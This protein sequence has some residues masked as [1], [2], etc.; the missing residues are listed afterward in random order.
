MNALGKKWRLKL[1]MVE[2]HICDTEGVFSSE[3]KLL[4]SPNLIFVLNALQTSYLDYSS[5]QVPYCA[6][7][8]LTEGN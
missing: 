1:S 6:R 3:K 8:Y 7:Q 5:F 4:S 2:I